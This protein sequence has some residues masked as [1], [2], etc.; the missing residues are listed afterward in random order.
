MRMRRI[1]RAR[2]S[3]LLGYGPGASNC[4]SPSFCTQRG[5]SCVTDTECCGG[6]CMKSGSAALGICELVPSSG[7]GS[8]DSM[9]EV[10]G[11]GADYDPATDTL[12]VCGGSCCS[13]ACFSRNSMRPFGDWTMVRQT[14]DWPAGC[15]V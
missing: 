6:Y 2:L 12:P 14:G 4:N 10:C 9:G 7:G 3:R 13:K 8:C 1:D 5:D 11:L 15:A